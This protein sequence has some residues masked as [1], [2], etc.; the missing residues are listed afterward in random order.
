MN[1]QNYIVKTFQG[2]EQVLASELKAMG[3]ETVEAQRRAVTF[4]GSKE[5]MYRVNFQARTAIRVLKPI[6][7]FQSRTE[8]E[9]YAHSK[10][11]D[12]TSVM[13]LSHKFAVD[14]VVNSDTFSHSRYVALKL[15]DAIAD[16]FKD[17]L[18]RRPFV[19]PKK[20]HIQFH[21]HIAGNDCTILMDSSGES[22]HRRG[23]RTNQSLAPLN[24][25]L[26]AGLIL[27]T[28]WDGQKPFIDPM[29]GSGTLLIEAA[30]IANGVAPGVFRKEFGFEHWLD[31]DA[32]LL[33][34][35]FNDDANE[36]TCTVPIVG[37]DLSKNAVDVTLENLRNSGLS[38]LVE[39]QKRSVFDFDPPQAPGLMITNPPYGERLKKEQLDV[40]YR[41]LGDCCKQRYS[42]YDIWIL[43]GN[44]E[45]MKSFG[46]RPS[47]SIAMLNGDIECKYQHFEMYQGSKRAK[48]QKNI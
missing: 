10:R 9:L 19:D 47:R 35:I 42:G 24:E 13:D 6:F 32:E 21:L 16:H 45:A 1:K 40:F 14:S 41:Q 20:P 36:R 39:V 34:N 4:T 27:L 25:V 11:F 43:T 23:Y 17:R 18:G 5:M 28:G 26:A 3:A 29:C 12:W 8:D 31:F 33:Q 46:L 38:K 7:T 15:K 48:F 2:L 37:G 30:L 44:L 22:L